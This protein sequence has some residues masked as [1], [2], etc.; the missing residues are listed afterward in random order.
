MFIFIVVACVI[1]R[2]EHVRIKS[3]CTCSGHIIWHNVLP[4]VVRHLGT[5][6]VHFLKCT[7]ASIVYPSAVSSVA[8]ASV[9]SNAIAAAAEL[10]SIP[11]RSK[12]DELE[13]VPDAAAGAANTNADATKS[14]T[15]LR[16]GRTSS[17]RYHH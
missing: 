12:E 10:E 7:V 8:C 1:Q 14:N 13:T 3:K 17:S 6:L 4:Q 2:R 5:C 16:R 15:A 9:G 11:T